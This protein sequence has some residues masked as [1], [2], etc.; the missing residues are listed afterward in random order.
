[1]ANSQSRSS[2]HH[3]VQSPITYLLKDKRNKVDRFLKEPVLRSKYGLTQ[4]GSRGTISTM[5]PSME[6][7]E[8]K[9]KKKTVSQSK[10]VVS[11]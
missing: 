1:M 4:S 10:H 6:S 5:G 2:H 8:V 9:P 7:Q 11:E 3:D